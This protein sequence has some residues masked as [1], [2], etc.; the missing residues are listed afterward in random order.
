MFRAPAGPP[1][2]R[3]V[4]TPTGDPYRE[5]L[6][7][8]PMERSVEPCTLAQLYGALAGAKLTFRERWHGF[9]LLGRSRSRVMKVRVQDPERVIPSEMICGADAPELVLDLALAI[10]PL[11]GPV[12]ADVRF[13]GTLFIDGRRDRGALGEEAAQRLQ[14]IGRRVATRAPISFPILV[15]LARR[16]RQQR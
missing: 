10:V 12:L 1:V 11:F 13:A 8:A 7:A 3:P 5:N 14:S 6:G 9:D 4:V 16:M 2:L 15:D